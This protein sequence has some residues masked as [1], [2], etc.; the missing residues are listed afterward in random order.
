MYFPD[1]R[2]LCPIV[3][4]CGITI[5][6]CCGCAWQASFATGEDVQAEAAFDIHRC[7]DFPL[8]VGFDAIMLKNAREFQR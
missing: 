7:Q 2:L 1:Q 6:N 5:Y 8:I 3:L 4:P